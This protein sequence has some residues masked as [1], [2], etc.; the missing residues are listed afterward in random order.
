MPTCGCRGGRCSVAKTCFFWDELEDNIVEEFD[1]AGVTIADYTTEPDH[2]GNV[3]SQYR[4]SQSSFF[5]YDALGS[6]LSVTD[7]S[8]NVTDTRAYTAF[9]E[10]TG[11]TGS[12]K[13]PFQYVGEKEY[14]FEEWLD[15]YSLRVRAYIPRVAR[16]LSRDRIDDDQLGNYYRYVSNSPVSGTDPSGLQCYQDADQRFKLDDCDQNFVYEWRIKW[17]VKPD[18]NG[19]ILQKVT[20]LTGIHFCDE[21]S[22]YVS[23]PCPGFTKSAKG[24]PRPAAEAA[25]YWELWIVKAG[26]VYSERRDGAPESPTDLFALAIPG[27]S[28]KDSD[29]VAI[30]KGTSFFVSV[31]GDPFVKEPPA[32]WES[33]KVFTD[34]PS[35]SL[36]AAR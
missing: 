21:N 20:S 3:I 13:F 32:G 19:F 6:T 1:D 10:V 24:P 4:S 35:R 17:I 7:E 26:K 9:G 27:G 29:G 14:Y 25:V 23:Q 15:S 16:W 33:W 11:A 31:E 28:I 5:H 8:Q 34:A 18:A 22:Y 30:Q 36:L 2:F 12:T